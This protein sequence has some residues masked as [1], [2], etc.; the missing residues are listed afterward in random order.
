MLGSI[1]AIII[2]SFVAMVLFKRI[3]F[4]KQTSL[5]N[6]HGTVYGNRQL[7]SK[8]VCVLFFALR[9]II[10]VVMSLFGFFPPIVI[11]LSLSS[12]ERNG[13]SSDNANGK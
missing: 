9:F 1:I 4:I 10:S 7:L 8:C 6:I 3:Q 11:L 12:G 2:F 13:S 5:S